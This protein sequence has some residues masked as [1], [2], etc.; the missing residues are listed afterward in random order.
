MTC[1]FP[2]L[3]PVAISLDGSCKP[4]FTVPS[5]DAAKS[6][7]GT[8]AVTGG[9]DIDVSVAA[10][11]IT[12]ATAHSRGTYTTDLQFKVQDTN[13]AFVRTPLPPP[14]VQPF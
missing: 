5:Y 13:V 10:K 7:V 14:I 12:W 6:C 8:V 9:N 1:D 11:E 4:D 2:D 3:D